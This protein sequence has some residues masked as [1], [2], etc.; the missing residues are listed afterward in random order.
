MPRIELF[1]HP[2]LM[3]DFLLQVKEFGAAYL[4]NVLPQGMRLALAEEL[5]KGP[6]EP[7]APELGSRKVEQRF[8]AYTLSYP[9]VGF[10]WTA[11]I[12]R[13]LEGMVRGAS[14]NPKLAAAK[15]WSP[16]DIRVHLY[17]S[18]FGQIGTH[19]DF[20]RDQLLIAV[21][22]I[23]GRAPFRLFADNEG[24]LL[25]AEWTAEAG[26]LVLLRGPGLSGSDCDDRPP[27]NAGRPLGNRIA[28]AYRMT[29]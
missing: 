1:N 26:G 10:P 12:G 29:V 19:R 17:P 9:M 13:Q 7:A 24:R 18:G 28:L 11:W 16:N 3:E 14:A 6:W 22:T 4:P 23:T 21:F 8:N 15:G 20:I 5:K 27:H 2:E 25:K